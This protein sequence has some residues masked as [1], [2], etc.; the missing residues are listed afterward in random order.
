MQ[1]SI[2]DL[3]IDKDNR[4]VRF[5][6]RLAA[7]HTNVAILSMADRKFRTIL[8]AVCLFFLLIPVWVV[9]IP[10][11]VDV[12]NHGARVFVIANY[13][14]SPFFQEHF[15]IAF[16]PIP[17]VALDLLLV[18]LVGYVGLW[19]A[20]KL[21]ISLSILLF[22]IGCY[23]VSASGWERPS[24]TVFIAWLLFYGSTFYFGYLNYLFGIGLFLIA[25][26]LWLRWRKKFSALRVVILVLVGSAS[27]LSHLSAI[28]FLGIAIAVVNLYDLVRSPEREKRHLVSYGCDLLIF[29]A[30]AAA[31]LLYIGNS[32]APS[33]LEWNSLS[34]KFAALFGPFRSFDIPVDIAIAAGL[35]VFFGSL[36]LK[37]EYKFDPLLFTLGIVFLFLFAVFPGVLVATDTDAR[38]VLPGFI[39]LVLSFRLEQPRTKLSVIFLLL[40]SL[41]LVRQGIVSYRFLQMEAI[42]ER[43]IALLDAIPPNS[44]VLAFRRPDAGPRQDRL[45][46]PVESVV[47][48]VSIESFS[49]SSKLFAIRGH[50]P[51][52]F[53]H[54]Q[55]AYGPEHEIPGKWLESLPNYD[56]LWTHD[57]SPEVIAQLEAR[58]VKVAD[59]GTTKIWKL[60]N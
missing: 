41:F 25:L 5:L 36:I 39:F 31:F 56:Y 53:R 46:R 7:D 59:D 32:G 34:G 19:T 60:K 4:S 28:V 6:F 23:L 1:K 10:P 38:F 2:I 33:A 42:L 47:N 30:P 49:F 29:L 15:E 9:E 51:L 58:A 24:L 40:L 37:R 57:V 55:L 52:V 26:G 17:N 12:I 48:M 27:Y 54:K 14:S 20:F 43:E 8:P 45:T 18:P 13:D 16:E 35:A 50:N 22:A 3:C 44:R 21:F 11:L